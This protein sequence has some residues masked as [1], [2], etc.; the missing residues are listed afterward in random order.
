[1]D[2]W[3]ETCS[4]VVEKLACSQVILAN[5]PFQEL[6]ATSAEDPGKICLGLRVCGPYTGVRILNH[7]PLTRR[8]GGFGP[9]PARVDI[10][11]FRT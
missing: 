1:M 8:S 11:V 9:F 5:Y 6:P 3:T 10:G 7:S 4:L 2:M